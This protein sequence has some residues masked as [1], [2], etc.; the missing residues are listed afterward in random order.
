MVDEDVG[1]PVA[2]RLDQ[3]AVALVAR[4]ARIF[5]KDEF[6]LSFTSLFIGLLSGT[7]PVGEWLFQ[8]FEGTRGF[9]GLLERRRLGEESFAALRSIGPSALPSQPLRRTRSARS[10][11]TE[12]ERLAADLGRR[13]VDTRHVFAAYIG[14]PNYHDDDFRALAMDRVK[15]ARDFSRAMSKFYPGEAAFWESFPSRVFPASSGGAIDSAPPVSGAAGRAER[16]SSAQTSSDASTSLDLSDHRLER[17]VVSVLRDARAL[18]VAAGRSVVEPLDLLHT[19]AHLAPVAGSPAFV[20]F[21]KIAG[22]EPRMATVASDV[23]PPLRGD[24]SA[25]LAWAQANLLWKTDKLWG[26]DLV[27]AALLCDDSAVAAALA[28]A[29]QSIQRV[30]D[31]WYIF[32]TTNASRSDNDWKAWWDYAGVP[33]PGPGRAAIALET[34][35]GKDRLG[36]EAEAR[37][38]ARLILDRD[39]QAPLSIGL[40]GDWGSG[41]S[42]F[43]EQL[44]S[45]IATL[46]QEHHPELYQRVIEIEF[47]AWHV[48]DSNLWA[49]LVTYIFDEIWANVS[50]NRQ[51]SIAHAQERLQ[52]QIE[53]AHGAVHEAEAQVQLA[54]AALTKTEEDLRQ[55]RT[56]LALSAYVSDVARDGLVRLAKAAGFRETLET[57]NDLEAAARNLATSGNRLRLTL[58]ALLERPASLFGAPVAVCIVLTLVAWRSLDYVPIEQLLS[59]QFARVAQWATVAVGGLAT[60]VAPLT[61]A[62]R[63]ISSLTDSLEE[64]RTEYE[65]KLA[66][67]DKGT[68]A[69]IADARRELESAEAS[70]SAAKARLAE[71]MNQQATL[72]PRRRLGAFLQERVQS[73]LY[74]S[75]QGIISLVYRDFQQL[76][77]YMKELRE[78][79]TTATGD[80]IEPFERIVLYVDDLDRCRPEHVVHMLEAVHLLLA[81]DLF[82]VVVAVDSRWLTRALEVH[83]KDLLAPMGGHA[84]EPLRAS[85]PQSYLEKIFQ[86]TYALGP[87]D[88]RYFAGYVASLAGTPEPGPSLA[89]A[90][91]LPEPLGSPAAGPTPKHGIPAMDTKSERGASAQVT[92]HPVADASASGGSAPAPRRHHSPQQAIAIYPNEQALICRLVPLLPT[93]RIAKRLVN[94]YRLIKASKAPDALEQFETQGRAE[95]CLLMLAILFGRPEIAGDL[96]R[97]LHERSTPFHDGTARLTDA[98]RKHAATQSASQARPWESLARTL[99]SIGIQSTVEACAREPLEIARY[100]LVSGHDWHTWLPPLA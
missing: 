14:L 92:V 84:D 62:A 55:R 74:R 79:K 56:K 49:S 76:S 4:A 9:R 65:Q 7:D 28:A 31:R 18:A 22:L 53:L 72:D 60:L 51:D 6:E 33:V 35:Q 75:Q 66:K 42:F 89:T 8:Q 46:K 26:R 13:G 2:M 17:H 87:M 39:V 85:T 71:L 16:S 10:A 59:A 98:V 90:G 58:V 43:I 40:L 69:E 24:V 70:V 41:K 32:L 19:I 86:I 45:Q 83:Y 91:P 5:D 48:S 12:A 1:S 93:P 34:D 63:R 23:A 61:A 15:L 95:S 68:R 80:G 81:L 54:R 77:K 36:V 64:I 94:V 97:K 52:Q 11:L 20:N 38:F 47:N 73:T 78:S 44:K 21:V 82:V 99:D 29:G 100:S 96:V 88:P 3:G 67:A 27:T 50:P 57:I 30:R 37:A 25:Q